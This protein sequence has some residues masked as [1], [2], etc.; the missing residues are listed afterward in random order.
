MKHSES[1][2]RRGLYEKAKEGKMT[3]LADKQDPYE[4]P[5]RPEV[6]LDTEKEVPEE[7]ARKLLDFLKRAG[8]DDILIR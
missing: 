4:P 8:F 3:N 7:S 5:L 6:I 1:G 2:P